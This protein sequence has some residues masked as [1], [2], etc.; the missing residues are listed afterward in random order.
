[1]CTAMMM[2]IKWCIKE[3]R[4]WILVVQGTEG[5]GDSLR[6]EEKKEIQMQ[7]FLMS[8]RLDRVKFDTSTISLVQ[9]K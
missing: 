8:P 9:I 3:N 6:T 7:N 5:R 4:K 2:M 1:M